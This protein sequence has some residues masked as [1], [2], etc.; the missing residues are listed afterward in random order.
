MAQGD[1]ALHGSSKKDKSFVPWVAS[2]TLITSGSIAALD[3]R[4]L[5]NYFWNRWQSKQQPP[6]QTTADDMLTI[7]PVAVVYLLDAAGYQSKTNFKDRSLILLKAGVA[8]MATVYSLKGLTSVQRPDSSNYYSFPSGHSAVAF[9]AAH[10]MHR[11]L[12]QRSILF[13]VAGYGTAALTGFLRMKHQ[14]H[15]ASDVLAGAGIGILCSELAYRTHRY[16]FAS[17]HSVTVSPYWSNGGG[18]LYLN[19]RL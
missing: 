2:V 1:T 10:F 11:E 16:R 5:D 18:G 6:F 7:F 17:K 13:S 8:T 15:W 3:H 12:G 9:M 4:I 14:R 19:W